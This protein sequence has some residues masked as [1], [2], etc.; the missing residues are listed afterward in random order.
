MRTTTTLIV[1]CVMGLITLGIVMLDSIDMTLETPKYFGRQLQWFV[2]GAIAAACVATLDYR[3]LRPLTWV[4]YGVALLLLALVFVP[5][6]GYATKGAAR[7]V[8]FMGFRFQPS[9]L[10][11][12]AMIIA[13]ASYVASHPLRMSTFVRG[14]AIPS[15]IVAPIIALVFL[16]PDYSTT[17]LLSAIA[18]VMLVTAGVKLRHLA[19]IALIVLCCVGVAIGTNENRRERIMALFQPQES[20][21]ERGLQ[22]YQA[23]LALGAGGLEGRGL[24][25]G[26]QKLGRIP[27]HQ[28]DF[29][30]AL[31]GEEL[32]FYGAFSVTSIYVL[33]TILGVRVAKYARD[34]FGTMLAIGITFA[35]GLQAF[36][37]IGV[38]VGVLPN[39]GMPLPFVSY[40]GTSLLMMMI[41]AG[42]LVSVSRRAS[43]NPFECEAELQRE[44]H[45]PATQLS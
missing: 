1:F 17:L 10:A 34:T 8:Q 35:I 6:V 37:N 12:V 3:R 2:L 36:I 32:G 22:A 20:K 23:R 16:E 7:W 13:L 26:R 40:G 18:G 4:I 33:L 29:I 31:I 43:V 21:E 39:T 30:F 15:L 24:G 44:G 5:S 45:I 28:T 19:P 38:V 9:E 27:E 42:L 14:I 25:S 41:A 11:K